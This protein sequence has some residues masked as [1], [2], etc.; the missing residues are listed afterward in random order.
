MKQYS[1][2]DYVPD[3]NQAHDRQEVHGRAMDRARDQKEVNRWVSDEASDFT[4]AGLQSRAR[5]E[6]KALREAFA[7]P[8]MCQTS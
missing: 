8:T 6:A 5:M 4:P 2:E 7:V 3:T 1:E